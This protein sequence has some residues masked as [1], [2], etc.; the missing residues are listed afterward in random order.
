MSPTMAIPAPTMIRRPAPRLA[1][2]PG[3]L[4]FQIWAPVKTTK[5]SIRAP[6]PHRDVMRPTLAA[7]CVAWLMARH[8]VI[9][10]D[11]SAM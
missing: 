3:V 8:R 10:D 6:S 5:P 4:A 1:P 2:S 11:R 9:S 7:K